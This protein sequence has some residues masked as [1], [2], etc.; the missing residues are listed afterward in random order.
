MIEPAILAALDAL[1]R[2]YGNECASHEIT[3]ARLGYAM[4]KIEQ[5]EAQAKSAKDG[6]VLGD[7]DDQ[8]VDGGEEEEGSRPRE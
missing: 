6:S 7:G 2:R 4:E 1:A 3:R 5:L 8:A